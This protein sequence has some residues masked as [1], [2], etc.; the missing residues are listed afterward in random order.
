ME[1]DSHDD[2]A[3][4]NHVSG[5]E[6]LSEKDET[7]LTQGKERSQKVTTCNGEIGEMR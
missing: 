1:K 6:I 7:F 3:D 2:G 4:R 5:D